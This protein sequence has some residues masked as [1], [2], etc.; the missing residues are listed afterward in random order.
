[1]CELYPESRSLANDTD[2]SRRLVDFSVARHTMFLPL[3]WQRHDFDIDA[4]EELFDEDFGDRWY[5]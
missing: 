5:W 1:M 3:Y 2:V 4:M